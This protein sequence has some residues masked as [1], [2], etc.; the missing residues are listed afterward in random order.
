MSRWRGRATSSNVTLA[1]LTSAIIPYV[2]QQTMV[3]VALP[4]LRADLHTT[5]NWVTW[6]FTGYLLMSVVATPLVGKLGDQYGR[7]R[8]LLAALVVFF[9]GS[10][11]AA[12]ATSIWM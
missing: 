12:F 7:T 5:Q 2:F 3:I 8:V 4:E 10:L 11:G 6:V 1:V 9:L